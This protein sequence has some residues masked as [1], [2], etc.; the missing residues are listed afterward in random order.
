MNATEA[1]I[2]ADQGLRPEFRRCLI[3]HG[4]ALEASSK[5]W[6]ASIRQRHMMFLQPVVEVTA[7]RR[8]V[9]AGH[10]GTQ[11]AHRARSDLRGLAWLKHHG[12]QEWDARLS[13][14]AEPCFKL[15]AY[16]LV[17]LGTDRALSLT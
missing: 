2:A 13:L 17:T 10:P 1:H 11:P 14:L 16:L 15:S 6:D 8:Q 4:W 7:S 5:P 3:M 9:P 12:L